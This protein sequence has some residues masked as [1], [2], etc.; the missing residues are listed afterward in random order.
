[1]ELGSRTKKKEPNNMQNAI[2]FTST[3]GNIY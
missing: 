3:P 1:M 2:T